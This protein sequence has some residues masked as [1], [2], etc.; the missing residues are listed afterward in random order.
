MSEENTNPE[1]VETATEVAETP[2]VED[3]APV[4]EATIVDMDATPA[5]ENFPE[6][7]NST[8]ASQ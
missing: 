7:D 3:A 4:G 8:E 5:G 6:H 2:V 1:V